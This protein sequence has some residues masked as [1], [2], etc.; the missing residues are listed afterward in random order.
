MRTLKTSEAAAL[1]NVT[2]NTLRAWE[3]RFGYPK[4]QRSR[5][6]H[7]LYTYAEVAALREALDEGLSISSAV[8]V[9][10]EALNTDVHAL[11]RALAAFAG[12]RADRALEASLGLRSVERTVEE[13]LLPALREIHRREGNDSAHWAYA[14]GWSSDWLRRARR[15][16]PPPA[17][18]L[19]LLIGDACGTELD[20]S[21]AQ[22]RALE[23]FCTRAGADVLTL[24]VEAPV[25]LADVAA[26]THPGAVVIAG[27]RIG[28]ETL[29]RWAYRVRSATGRL[30][31]ALFHRDV[32][33]VGPESRA[34]VLS[35]AP[36]IAQA[37]LFA[38]VE[39]PPTAGLPR[40]REAG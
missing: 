20:P 17:R 31:L 21:A 24:S 19:S 12:E 4:P 15:L 37:E 36:S 13:V 40:I 3:R 8:S 10:R 35:P 6:N 14:A 18:G 30:P 32:H 26:A 25:G 38:L 28:D 16:S 11:V 9:A 27:S 7:R 5:G 1:L 34:K 22:L 23:L 39:G 2:A 33:A 29:S